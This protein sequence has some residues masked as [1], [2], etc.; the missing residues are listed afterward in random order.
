[1]EYEGG[2]RIR[3]EN[4]LEL[5][6]GKAFLHQLLEQ[7]VF[8]DL[9][10]SSMTVSPLPSLP[11]AVGC[12]CKIQKETTKNKNQNSCWTISFHLLP[13]RF[14]RQPTNKN[15]RIS[16]EIVQHLSYR[17]FFEKNQKRKKYMIWLTERVWCCHFLS[18]SAWRSFRFFSVSNAAIRL[19]RLSCFVLFRRLLSVRHLWAF[20]SRF[21]LDGGFRPPAELSGSYEKIDSLMMAA[22]VYFD[23]N[24]L[25]FLRNGF[26]V[27]TTYPYNKWKPIQER[28]A[29]QQRNFKWKGK[30]D[31]EKQVIC[32]YPANH[33]THV[34]INTSVDEWL[35]LICKYLK[36]LIMRESRC[37][38]NDS[39]FRLSFWWLQLG[40]CFCFVE[41]ERHVK[42]L[43]LEVC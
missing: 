35:R 26:V 15:K 6:E 38:V 8:G 40:C 14:V 22:C 34:C 19:S 1:M 23:E 4:F 31:K 32:I 12:H 36:N 25:L 29:T 3:T 39:L 43:R 17:F 16:N 20:L 2:K 33:S 42:V 37:Q 27:L 5:V 9:L 10:T 7:S 30:L 24:V 21:H 11:A 41:R 13:P 28:Y 18:I